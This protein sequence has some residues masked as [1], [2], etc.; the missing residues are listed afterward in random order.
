MIYSIFN[1]LNKIKK[2]PFFFLS[3]LIYAIGN[4][5]QQITIA[6]NYTKSRGKV[7]IILKVKLLKR[8]LNY[9]ICNKSLF[10]DLIFDKKKDLK[11]Y[12]ITNIASYFLDIEFIFKRSFVLFFRKYFNI[13]FKEETNF[14]KIGINYIFGNSVI[15]LKKIDYKDIKPFYF[16]PNQIDIKEQQK[17]YCKKKL[18]EFGLDE[19]EKLV[20]L[21][22]R[23]ANFKNDENR[24]NYFNSGNYRNSDINN[25]IESINFL[26]N[27]GYYV[28]R[29]GDSSS[30]KINFNHKKFLDYSKSD[31]KEDIMDFYLIKKCAFYIGTQSG[32]IDIAYMFNKPV[33]TT[34][35]CELFACLPRKK[36]DRGIFKK[37]YYGDSQNCIDI[38]TFAALPFKY[39]C[40]QI[41]IKDLKFEENSPEEIYEATVEFLESLNKKK[42]LSNLQIQFNNLLKKQHIELFYQR[43]IDDH[44]M[45][46]QQDCLYF[47]RMFKSCK[48]VFCNSYL[49]KNI[50]VA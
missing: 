6:S 45:I 44:K 14:P 26:I 49:K 8:I 42:N 48:G 11:Y 39:H 41:E 38:Q 30:K 23:D 24:K 50:K 47:V 18:K 28:I 34:N 35:M 33:F 13:K 15:D 5:S 21:H 31:M 7:L 17:I 19:T 3:P 4:A 36:I 22:V 20:C 16:Y 25:Y 9:S 46:D 1:K 10:H 43:N 40:P 12:F 32:I 2:F 37:I 27:Q 29:M